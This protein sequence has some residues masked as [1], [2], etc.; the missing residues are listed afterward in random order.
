MV[1]VALWVRVTAKPGKEKDVAEFL[2]SARS[3]VEEEPDTVAWFAVQ[4]DESTFAIFDAFPDDSGRQAHLAGGVG[5]A[6]AE[7]APELLSEPPTIENLDV[8]A[9][10]LPA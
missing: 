2:R 3:V 5:K 10:K 9:S 6:L 8:L 4:L 1:S 7:H